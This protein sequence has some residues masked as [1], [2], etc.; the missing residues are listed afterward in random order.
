MDSL[1][2]IRPDHLRAMEE[3]AHSYASVRIATFPEYRKQIS[4]PKLAEELKEHLLE[5]ARSIA[6]EEK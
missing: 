4:Q 1:K 6:A 2:E 3:T 5:N